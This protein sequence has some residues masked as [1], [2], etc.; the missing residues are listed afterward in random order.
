MREFSREA[1]TAT[2]STI[3]LEMLTV[4]QLFNEFNT[5]YGT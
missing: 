3:L 1:V 5:L 4:A 2:W